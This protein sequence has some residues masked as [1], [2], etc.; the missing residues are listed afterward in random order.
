MGKK[1]LKGK[2]IKTKRITA[3]LCTFFSQYRTH[4]L[5]IS[6]KSVVFAKHS[7]LFSLFTIYRTLTIRRNN[8]ERLPRDDSKHFILFIT[9]NYRLLLL[10]HRSES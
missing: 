10:A 9:H 4:L 6:E 2:K 5:Y 1:C 3:C 7:I 8:Y